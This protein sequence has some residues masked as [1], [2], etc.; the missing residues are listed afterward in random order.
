M[1][2]VLQQALQPPPQVLVL[3]AVLLDLQHRLREQVGILVIGRQ[4]GENA[5]C[6]IESAL[7]D[8]FDEGKVEGRLIEFLEE[9]LELLADSSH[10]NSIIG[11]EFVRNCCQDVLL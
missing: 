4:L 9:S 8:E 1:G 3:L 10:V 11:L 5:G 7:G 2:R 6:P